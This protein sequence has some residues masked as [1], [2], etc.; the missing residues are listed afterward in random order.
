MNFEPL[1]HTEEHGIIVWFH[2]CLLVLIRG[3]FNAFGKI[4][5]EKDIRKKR[6]PPT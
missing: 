4:G 5:S 3:F 2:P 1:M 6:T